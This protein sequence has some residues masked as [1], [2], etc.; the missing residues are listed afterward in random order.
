M[1]R[2]TLYAIPIALLQVSSCSLVLGPEEDFGPHGLSQTFVDDAPRVQPRLGYVGSDACRR[3]HVSEH[4]AWYH[5]FHRTMTQVATAET[6]AAPD[7]DSGATQF[8]QRFSI[9]RRGDEVYAVDDASERKIVLITGSHH[10]Q[11]YWLG[12]RWGDIS[13][14]PRVYLLGNE[15]YPIEGGEWIDRWHA[16][17]QPAP[18]GA[19]DER[20][21]WNMI[22]YQCHATNGR[23][24][25]PV[26][27]TTWV[28]EFG[29]SCEACHGPGEEHV[30]TASTRGGR[31]VVNPS[32]LPAAEANL[33]CGYCHSARGLHDP[34][35]VRRPPVPGGGEP[36]QRDGFG[37]RP[38]MS[39]FVDLTLEANPRWSEE[40][41]AGTYW[42]D[43]HVYIGGREY[44]GVTSSPCYQHDD[45]ERKLTCFSCHQLHRDD[46]DPREL[47]AWAD[48][49][50]KPG[51]RTSNR[52]CTQCHS[53]FEED[54]VLVAHTHHSRE[55]GGSRCYNCHMNPANYVLL[56]AV[57]DHAIRSPSVAHTLETGRP[58]A[59]NQCHLDRTLEWSAR[60]LHDWYGHEV[61]E[62][63]A[64]QREV[65]ASILWTTKGNPL[66]RALVA[67]SFGWDEAQRASGTD[68][69]IP[70]AVEL[71]D[72]PVDAIR[73]VARHSAR[74]FP[75]PREWPAFDEESRRDRT[76]RVR[77]SWRAAVERPPESARAL[78]I[79]ADGRFRDVEFDRLLRD[80]PPSLLRISE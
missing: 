14:L 3:C 39:E 46:D 56:K 79:D 12:E 66:Q 34:I 9:E 33:V 59:C 74:R 11:V 44:H 67:W 49:Q 13:Q 48:D 16:F 76:K 22:C 17:V 42:N 62:L 53:E 2:I 41:Y 24:A 43:G 60:R 63:T 77:E 37:F 31:D 64:E 18:D 8:G 40:D 78:L 15:N 29:I 32:R 5:S 69:M 4:E 30:A 1:S 47:R 68:W 35:R 26:D 10:M 55:S 58:N 61:P 71:T 36:W 80:R 45:E 52:A 70:V 51:L 6:V 75:V 21:R 28:S 25:D 20:G 73:L 19:D 65:A 7:G 54:E 50:L 72:D 23:P 38:G 27:G 57:R